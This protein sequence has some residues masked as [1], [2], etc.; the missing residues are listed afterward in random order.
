M[1]EKY[2]DKGLRILSVHIQPRESPDQVK[3][4]AKA[5]GLEQTI[6]L[7]GAQVART[8]GVRAAPTHFFVD[9]S[10]KIVDKHVGTPADLEK[11]L[12]KLLPES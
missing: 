8:Y 5:Q 4:Y 2:R 12:R 10:G 9:P 3:S 11:R 7:D 6:L 1:A